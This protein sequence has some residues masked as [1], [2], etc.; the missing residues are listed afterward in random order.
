MAQN[1]FM[2]SFVFLIHVYRIKRKYRVARK[3]ICVCMPTLLFLLILRFCY[4][5]LSKYTLKSLLFDSTPYANERVRICL[6]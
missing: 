1:V 3:S 2:A 5:Y 4:N 6:E